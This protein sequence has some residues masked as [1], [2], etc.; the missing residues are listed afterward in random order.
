MSRHIAPQLHQ[1]GLCKVMALPQLLTRSYRICLVCASS[2]NGHCCSA[3]L[4]GAGLW[5]KLSSFKKKFT[6]PVMIPIANPIADE[7]ASEQILSIT[8][9]QLEEGNLVSGIKACQKAL[10]KTESPG[11]MVLNAKTSPMDLIT[12]IPILCEER[13]VP[14]IFVKD[15][16]W[17]NG[18]SCVL[19]KISDG[20]QSTQ[21]VLSQ[22]WRKER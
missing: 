11:L 10:L 17:I 22:S 7:Q 19:L 9:K 4:S 16:S 18:F 1:L 5:P 15:T 21:H 14:Y 13:G 8:R 20:C 2:L 3:V 12:H 6:E